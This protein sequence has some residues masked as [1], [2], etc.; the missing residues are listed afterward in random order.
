MHAGFAAAGVAALV[1]I[2]TPVALIAATTET[3]ATASPSSCA[4]IY[5][6]DTTG[7]NASVEAI[8]V[9]TATTYRTPSGT[10]ASPRAVLAVV[11]AGFTESGMRNL[12]NAA[13]PT[14][15]TL[16]H[17][18]LGADHYSVGYLQG[19]VGADGSDTFGWGNVN[20]V[21][22]PAQATAKFMDRATAL[23]LTTSGDAANL[24][25]AVQASGTPD[26]S[27]YR[28]NLGQAQALLTDPNVQQSCTVDSPTAWD[29]LGNP[30][31][32]AQAVA[33]DHALASGAASNLPGW[34]DAYV[35]Y[36]YGLSQSG[37]QDAYGHWLAVPA[38][39]KHAG[40]APPPKGA[41]VFWT[42]S[43]PHGHVAVS[44]GDGTVASTDYP[45]KGH[46]G[47]APIADIDAWG[48][49]LGYTAPW[50]PT[51]HL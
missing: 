8:A 49:R 26:G 47:I 13:V 30:N 1:F 9:V 51:N 28:A 50:F 20:A 29:Q 35:S 39:L 18:A 46:F 6:P 7:P 3:S 23:D 21:M 25:Q 27:N 5:V 4:P 15:L 36:A 12:A 34:C 2:G 44:M 42:T 17:D 48:T 14:S 40:N 16:P 43:N 22:D 45:S 38:N 24:A 32:V 10:A 31:T 19:Q 11:A 41:L 33:W 37:I